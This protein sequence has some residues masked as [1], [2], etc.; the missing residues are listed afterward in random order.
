MSHV[1]YECVMSRKNKSC[2]IRMSHVTSEYTSQHNATH[3][4][5]LQHTTT[6]C[7]T[8]QHAATHQQ[9]QVGV[10]HDSSH[11]PLCWESVRAV[12]TRLRESAVRDSHFQKSQGG[13]ARWGPVLRSPAISLGLCVCVCVCVCVCMSAVRDGHS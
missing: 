2:H 7:N 6:H 5:T 1:T 4:N 13:V 12:R 8:L 11:G 9:I 3:C 10:G